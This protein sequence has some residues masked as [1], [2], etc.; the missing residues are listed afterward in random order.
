[1]LRSRK[2]HCFPASPELD[3]GQLRGARAATRQVREGLSDLEVTAL[4][5]AAYG[6]GGGA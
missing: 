5:G 4:T 6:R 2:K 3:K 1:M